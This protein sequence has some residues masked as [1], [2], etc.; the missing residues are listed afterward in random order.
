VKKIS[1]ISKIALSDP[2]IE[3]SYERGDGTFTRQVKKISK[4]SKIALSDPAIESSYERES[5][6]KKKKRSK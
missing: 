1:K 4:I 3:S 5:D 6:K 2:A